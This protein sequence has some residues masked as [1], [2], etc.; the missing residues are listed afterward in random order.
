MITLYRLVAGLWT[1]PGKAPIDPGGPPPPG[2]GY[3]SGAYGS[4]KYGG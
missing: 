1:A 2:V 4:G 3:G